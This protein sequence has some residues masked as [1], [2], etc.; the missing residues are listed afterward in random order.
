MRYDGAMRAIIAEIRLVRPALRGAGLRR[1]GRL[2]LPGL[3]A[4]LCGCVYRMPILQGNY[5]DPEV[6]AQVKPGMTHSQVRYLLGTPMVPDAFDDTRW[7]YDYYFKTRRLE[8]PQRGHVVVHFEKNLVARVD[9]D[10]QS[11]PFAPVSARG[12]HAPQPF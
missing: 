7:D 6:I 4:L 10:V 3:A 1:M 11:A 5:L 2:V 12:A 8:T 9:S